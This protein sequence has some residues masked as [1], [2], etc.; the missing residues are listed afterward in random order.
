MKSMMA[1]TALASG[2]AAVPVVAFVNVAA[3]IALLALPV[4]LVYKAG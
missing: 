4:Y 1:V 2:A 3:G